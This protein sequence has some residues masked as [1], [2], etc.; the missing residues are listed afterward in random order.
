[1]KKG[2]KE[3]VDAIFRKRNEWREFTVE[4]KEANS[5]IFNRYMGKTK[6]TI[7]SALALSKKNIDPVL[8]LDIWY[9]VGKKFT[10]TPDWFWK[11]ATKAD[12][13]ITKLELDYINNLDLDRED[14]KMIKLLEPKWDK[15]LKEFEKTKK[16]K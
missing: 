9:D 2:F 7:A 10:R 14:I 1:M 4:E 15:S 16:K 8:T 13:R 12:E 3:T 11:G 5:F 6:D